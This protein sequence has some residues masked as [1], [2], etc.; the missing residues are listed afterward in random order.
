MGVLRVYKK[1]IVENKNLVLVSIVISMLIRLFIFYSNTNL[2]PNTLSGGLLWELFSFEFFKN[3]L[4]SFVF[5]SI[6]GLAIMSYAAY[7]NSKYALIRTRTYLVYICMM[8]ALSCHPVFVYMNQ[9]YIVLFLFLICIDTLFSSY[10]EA[11]PARKSYAIGFFLALCSLLSIHMLF[12]FI[13]FW[14]GFK[15]M[16]SFSLK[17][18]ITSIL[19]FLTVY[20]LVFC[21]FLWKDN[22]SGFRAIFMQINFALPVTLP[23]LPQLFFL[24]FNIILLLIIIFD[25]QI[26]SF[27]DKIRIRAKGYFLTIIAIS[28]LLFLVFS[29]SFEAITF[30]YIFQFSYIMI[31]VHFFALATRV[32]HVYLFYIFILVTIISSFFF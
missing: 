27:Q 26:N 7:L 24:V 6:F 5:S 32:W 4:I 28:S 20:W 8:L 14:I 30:Y 2:L 18:L 31:I 23:S 10:Q 22:L 12:Y 1:N 15:M 9:A 25:N 11:N 19:G 29:Q 16:R 3:K 17:S 21:L 13:L